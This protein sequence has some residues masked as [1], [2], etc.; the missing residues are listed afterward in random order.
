MRTRLLSAV[1]ALALSS[2]ALTR[3]CR[4]TDDC[5]AASGFGYTCGGDGLCVRAPDEPR[6][7]TTWPRDLYANPAEG[8]RLVIATVVDL[9][10]ETHVARA[11]AVQL[12]VEDASSGASGGVAGRR[13]GLVTCTIAQDPTLDNLTRAQANERVVQHLEGALDVPLIVGPPGSGDVLEAFEATTRAVFISPSA[14]SPTLTGLE[15]V[16]A[17]DEAPGRLW[18]TAPTDVEQ[19]DRIAADL[20]ARGIRNAALVAQVGTYGD[21]LVTLLGERIAGLQIERFENDGQ[22]RGAVGSIAA[23]GATEVIFASSATSDAIN[24]LTAAAG[25]SAFAM[26]RFFL[27]D[28]AA[29]EDLL[30]GLPSD[31]GFRARIRGTRA[32]LD[33]TRAASFELRYRVAFGASIVDA[34]SFTAH[35][36]DAGWLAL[37]AVAW[38]TLQEGRIDARAIG[39][40]LRHVSSGGAV[41]VGEASWRDVVAAFE[42]GQS[43]DVRGASGAL[44]Y[45]PDT[46]ERS[47]DGQSFEVWRINAAGDGFCTVGDASCT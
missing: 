15:A 45:D 36:Y 27:T 19:A 35:A 12:A 9:S 6:C 46:E 8:R 33:A 30:R 39:R 4:S 14:T 34:L 43:I 3:T 26:R 17:S 31:A 20:S 23:G 41:D 38:A 29:N 18:R 40:G 24:F 11:N 28:A 10:L 37:Y 22:L 5:R 47:E 16:P 13:F 1:V 44:D 42:A 7:A 2:C 25:D 32:A 21:G